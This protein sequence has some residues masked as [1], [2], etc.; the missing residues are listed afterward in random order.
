MDGEGM[1]GDVPMNPS[2][3]NDT[4]GF[5]P[6][7]NLNWTYPPSWQYYPTYY[8]QYWP[9]VPSPCPSCGH[10]PTCGS[11]RS[12]NTWTITTTTG[13][14]GFDVAKTVTVG[15]VSVASGKLTVTNPFTANSPTNEEALAMQ[16]SL[17]N[18][19]PSDADDHDE[20]EHD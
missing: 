20:C 19:C 1:T 14:T 11:H 8:P 9:S 4:V 2:T 5:Y 6:S 10:C 7:N 17:V 16:A 3:W 18:T 15:D 12:P 13:T